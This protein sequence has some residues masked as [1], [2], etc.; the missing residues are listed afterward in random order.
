MKLRDTIVLQN[1]LQNNP[2]YEHF[3][4]FFELATLAKVT[5]QAYY[6]SDKG[7]KIAYSGIPFPFC[8]ALILDG[9]VQGKPETLLS[10]EID[11]MHQ[12]AIPFAC[13]LEPSYQPLI[14]I[15]EK[16]GL[17]H[18]GTFLGLQGQLSNL[19]LDDKLARQ[20]GAREVRLVESAE[21]IQY[22]VDILSACF[23]FNQETQEG[24]KAFVTYTLTEKQNSV[25]HYLGVVEG[26]PVATL[27][28]LFHSH[29]ISFWNG[30]T[31]ADYRKQGA[32]STIVEAVL[33]ESKAKGYQSWVTFLMN[34]M[35][36]SIAQS[37]GGKVARE[38][39]TLAIV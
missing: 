28:A 27:S 1:T 10:T 8:N 22:F 25:K 37:F 24:F 3:N 33:K 38:L 5:M 11:N 4:Y 13:F 39:L 36:S 12:K 18:I 29:N 15:L 35:A 9:N 19:N 26:K 31:L 2:L 23:E 20:T 7:L 14:P 30:A 34:D 21:D 16:K 6:R 32:C 17:T